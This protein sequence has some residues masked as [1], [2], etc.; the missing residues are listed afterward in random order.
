MKKQ[1]SQQ[2]K[3]I[4]ILRV[5]RNRNIGI[6]STLA[7]T[8][9]LLGVLYQGLVELKSIPTMSLWIWLTICG[10]FSLLAF[11]LLYIHKFKTLEKYVLSIDPEF[12]DHRE[13][14]RWFEYYAKQSETKKIIP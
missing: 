1:Q 13:F 12:E 9:Y 2:P 14:D 5:L 6:L 4:K 8:I 10:S 7:S 3:Q 11:L